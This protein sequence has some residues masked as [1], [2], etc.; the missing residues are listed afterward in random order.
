MGADKMKRDM[1]LV[2][3]LL[4]KIADAKEPPTFSALVPDRQNKSPEYAHAAYQMHMLIEEVGLVSG[5]DVCSQSGDDW[6]DLKLTWAGN[7]FLD[8]IRD[9]TVWAKTKDG[10]KKLGGA[11]W[12]VLVDMAKA[13][14]KA[15]AKK[16]LGLDL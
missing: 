2:R 15:E 16:R 14:A 12:D 13:Y 3:E 5:I 10:L 11:S 9:A 7:D 1:D 4:L 8:T 6:L